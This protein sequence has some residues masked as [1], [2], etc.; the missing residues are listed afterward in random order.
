MKQHYFIIQPPNGGVNIEKKI[1]T[2]AFKLYKGMHMMR[3]FEE[4]FLMLRFPRPQSPELDF[5][6]FFHSPSITAEKYAEFKGIFAIELSD[7]LKEYSSLEF[8]NFL[9]FIRDSN[10]NMQFIFMVKGNK[11][12]CK[13]IYN[14]LNHTLFY[15]NQIEL[16][17]PNIEQLTEYILKELDCQLTSGA[18][19]EIKRL[20]EH[21]SNTDDFE[22]YNTARIIIGYILASKES[23]KIK[24]ND[25]KNVEAIYKVHKEDK[26]DVRKIGFLI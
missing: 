6:R 24:A 4:S 22:G 8:E 16:Q 11:E 20:L 9:D 25:I 14:V 1:E 18:A 17:Y 3:A 26:K 2:M 5:R 23:D 10:A 21:I 19:N 7:W 12:N 15:V 13:N